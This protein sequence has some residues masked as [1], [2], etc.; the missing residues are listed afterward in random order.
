MKLSLLEWFRSF[1]GEDF[2][3]GQ[4]S[5]PQ[6]PSTADDDAVMNAL[7][8]L[9]N[10]PNGREAV[11]AAKDKAH[12]DVLTQN[13]VLLMRKGIDTSK[14]HKLGQGAGG[15]AYDMGNGKVFK[16]T[17]DANEAKV[18]TSLKGKS[19]PGVAAVY[20]TWKFP[21]GKMYGIILEK[22]FPFETWP[23][24]IL[25]SSIEEVVDTFHLKGMLQKHHG[26]WNA[27]WQE[28]AKSPFVDNNQEDLKR[29]LDIFQRIVQSLGSAGISNYFDI[30]LGNLGKRPSGEVVVF[31]VGFAGG[32][33]EPA[34]LNEFLRWLR[35]EQRNH[36]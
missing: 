24:D 6:A 20:D 7:Q 34:T 14:L 25:K 12:G 19:I 33:Q 21:S 9:E 15:I 27:I 23:N 31:D 32:G 29:A 3:W 10:D 36:C 2:D 22:V 8:A 35:R 1:L 4:F 13:R 5:K 18:S 17:E 16:V 11:R 26:D 30:H 28:I